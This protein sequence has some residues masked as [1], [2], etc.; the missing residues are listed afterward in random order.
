MPII[1]DIEPQAEEGRFK[2]EQVAIRMVKERPLYSKTPIRSP[3]DAIRV[4]ADALL[5]YDRE[6]FAVVNFQTDMRPINF[7]IISMGCL[8][9]SLVHPREVIKAPILSNAS[10]VILFHNHP[11]GT[12]EPSKDDIISTDQLKN[13]FNLMGIRVLD[14]IIVGNDKRYYSFCKK[15]KLT[16]PKKRNIETLDELDLEHQKVDMPEKNSVAENPK[17]AGN[18]QT[19]VSE[20][21][22][23]SCGKSITESNE[24]KN[25]NSVLSGLSDCKHN[26]AVKKP[27]GKSTRR[28]E[29][30]R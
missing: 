11:S 26:M 19:V 23:C 20:Y 6:V 29:A 18:T 4:M 28:Q 7:T 17:R 22:T 16:L 30:V 12:I 15:K 1:P 14:H 13:A 8:D 5:D 25:R 27:Y 24:G 9:S 3:K 10:G 21:K 2:L